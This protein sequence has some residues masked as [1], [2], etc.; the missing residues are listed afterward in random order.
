MLRVACAV[1]VMLVFVAARPAF[2]QVEQSSANEAFRRGDDAFD[3]GD[4]GA[5][6]DAYQRSL[7][8]VPSPNS[9]LLVARSLARLQRWSEALAQYETTVN[10]AAERAER[11]PRFAK[12]HD[13]AEEEA[14]DVRAHV[15]FVRIDAKLIPVNARVTMDGHALASASWDSNLPHDL[16]KA[17]IVVEAPGYVTKTLEPNIAAAAVVNVPNAPLVL[18]PV[19]SAK[20]RSWRAVGVT[21]LVAGG[22]S[23]VAS[24]IL[25]I[26]TQSEWDAKKTSC[27]NGC[28]SDMLSTGRALTSATY[29]TLAIGLALSAIGFIVFV[30]GSGRGARRITSSASWV[31]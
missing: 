12:T 31:F 30:A 2:A 1:I 21:A 18:A 7:A 29:A 22:A 13:V 9:R 26:A 6:L 17:I 28:A 23:L 19:P 14:K 3:R 25:A 11:D 4:F 8:L 20:M 5:A 16:G 15:G 24:G 10:E 27:V